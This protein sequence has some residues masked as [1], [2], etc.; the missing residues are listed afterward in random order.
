MGPLAQAPGATGAFSQALMQMIQQMTAQKGVGLLG[1]VLGFADGGHVS[2]PGTSRSDSIPAMLSDGE[3]VV[4][5][6]ATRKHRA[7]LEAIN[8]GKAPMLASGGI[9][10]RNAF[11][12]VYSPSL[13]INVAGSGN[14]RQDARLADRIADRVNDTLPQDPFRRSRAQQLAMQATDLR[15]VGGRNA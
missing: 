10:S 15:S 5:A 11:S 12:N 6:R 7:A 3:F 1:G 14:Q 4:N 2:G 8:A 13:N 9:V